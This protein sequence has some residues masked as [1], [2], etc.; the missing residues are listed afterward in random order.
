MVHDKPPTLWGE[1]QHTAVRLS[2]VCC[3]SGL[4]FSFFLGRVSLE[5]NCSLPV[6]ASKTQ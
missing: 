4:V 3:F 1:A 6:P 5:V 2:K